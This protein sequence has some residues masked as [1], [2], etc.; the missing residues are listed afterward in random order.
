MRF[1]YQGLTEAG[2]NKKGSIDAFDQDAAVTKLQSKGIYATEIKVAGSGGNTGQGESLADI[3]D[4]L[5]SYLPVKNAQKIFFFRQLALMFRSGLS[6]TE[7]LTI[8]TTIQRGRIRLIIINLNDEISAGKSFSQ[9]MEKYESIFTPLALHMLRSAEASGE[10]EPALLRVAD[11]ME[12]KAEIKTQLISTMTYPVVVL[13]MAIGVF[14]YLMATVIPKFASYFEKTGKT[15]PAQMVQMM[16]I[17]DFLI[18][19][20]PYM[21]V[22]V[23]VIIGSII[24]TYSRPEG[25]MLIDRFLLKVPLVGKM[26]SANAMSQITWGLSTLLQSG[27]SVVHSLQI[28]GALINCKPIAKDVISASEDI[29]RGADMGKS[30]RKTYIEDLIQQMT[31]VGERT[32]S[33]VSIMHDAGEFYEQRIKSISKSIA[34]ATEPAAILLIGG[35]VGYVYYGFF[36]TIASA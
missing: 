21:V 8:L 34:T 16:N 9:A 36:T 22:A 12:R 7:A 5:I 35:L 15:P 11:F 28:I 19:N 25:R 20:W 4:Q 6:V 31:L 26:I 14:F 30:F 33:M 17:S 18:F 13:L 23:I 29:L 32:G 27:I 10:L 1:H 24:Y 3:R 2:E